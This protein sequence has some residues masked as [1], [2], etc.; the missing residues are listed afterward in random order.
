[1][2]VNLLASAA[3]TLLTFA[4]LV[5]VSYHTMPTPT[6]ATH[7]GMPVTNLAPVQVHA[8]AADFRAAAL[9]NDTNLTAATNP[10]APRSADNDGT[11][12]VR[13]LDSP[14]A[15]PYYSFGNTLGRVNKE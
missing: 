12:P 5:A 10:L 11:G 2:K 6:G 4:S 13:L 1:M 14:L 7:Q 8:S 15:M 9:L 3:A